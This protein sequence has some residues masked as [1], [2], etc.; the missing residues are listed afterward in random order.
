MQIT[1]QTPENYRRSSTP[2]SRMLYR[3]LP[4]RSRPREACGPAVTL[5]HAARER[6]GVEQCNQ[7]HASP[8]SPHLPA[9]ERDILIAIF[10][11][12]A[13]LPGG[14]KHSQ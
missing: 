3:T 1:D 4:S 11:W 12:R 9:D 6:A 2:V 13:A 10:G 7:L 5:P 8:P 14:V